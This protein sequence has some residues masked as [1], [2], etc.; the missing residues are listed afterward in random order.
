VH[1]AS[2]PLPWP[3]QPTHCQ[4]HPRLLG[5]VRLRES[6]ALLPGAVVPLPVVVLLA[7]KAMAVRDDPEGL[8]LHLAEI[9]GP[10]S[11]GSIKG[12]LGSH[13]VNLPSVAIDCHRLFEAWA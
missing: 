11:I 7:A 13:Q 5:V 6:V 2:A 8:W 9:R 1:A 12:V 10:L 4:A 3:G